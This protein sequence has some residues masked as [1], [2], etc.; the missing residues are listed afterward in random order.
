MS[1]DEHGPSVGRAWCP[2]EVS[3]WQR[4]E[5]EPESMVDGGEAVAEPVGGSK[6]AV[7]GDVLLD[8]V[9]GVGLA[10]AEAHPDQCAARR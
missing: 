6:A 1:S 10:A 4:R 8:A 3:H 9:R 7:A 2:G 5:L